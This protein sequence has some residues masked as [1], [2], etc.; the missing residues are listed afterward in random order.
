MVERQCAGVLL[1]DVALPF[2]DPSLAGR[3]VSD[4]LADPARFDGETLADPIEG[5]S[6]GACKA[7]IMRQPD[8]KPW[9]HSFA[10]GRTTY[11]LRYDFRSA[12][13]AIG[14]HPPDR[15]ARKFVALC[16]SRQTS[17]PMS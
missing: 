17:P 14:R 4:V 12:K 8:G 16:L 3:T 10:H 1:P 15:S 6:Y 7:K 13:A 11:A 5:V 9:I 2:D